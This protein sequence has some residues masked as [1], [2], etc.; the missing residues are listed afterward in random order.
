MCNVMDYVTN[1][2]FGHVISSQQFVSN[3]PALKIYVTLE[4]KTSLKR[5]F[6]DIEIYAS[7]ES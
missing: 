5:K 2:N 3:Q 6:F 7:S 1:Y 4:H